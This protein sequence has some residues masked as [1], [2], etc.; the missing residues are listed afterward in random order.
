MYDL[1]PYWQN[2]FNDKRYK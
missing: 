2:S 1:N